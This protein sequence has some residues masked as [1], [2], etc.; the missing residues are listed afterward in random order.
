MTF[1]VT[2]LPRSR[3]AWL[4]NFLTYGDNLCYHEGILGCK[5]IDEYIDKIGNG[6]DSNTLLASFDHTKFFP[7]AKVVIIDST[8]EA[9][10]QYG[11]DYYNKDMTVPMHMLKVRL[12]GMRGLHVPFSEINNNLKNIWEYL[13]EEPYNEKRANMLVDLNI[14]MQNPQDM[15]IKTLSNFMTSTKGVL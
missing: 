14:Q 4:A 11:W 5:N 1:F 6:G 10:V 7:D 2:G 9:S 15:D 3:T 13:Y 8:I 12:D